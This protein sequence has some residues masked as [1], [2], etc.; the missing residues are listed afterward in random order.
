MIKLENV[1][2]A[3]KCCYL[4]ENIESCPHY[5]APACLS[6][7]GKVEIGEKLFKE[8]L[9]YLKKYQREKEQA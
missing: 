8:M 2:K 7:C 9:Y 3:A 4:E 6:Y 5:N 1:I